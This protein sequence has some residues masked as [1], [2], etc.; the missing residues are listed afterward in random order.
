V[1]AE[2]VRSALRAGAPDDVRQH[3]VDVDGVRWPPKQAL[4]LATGIDRREFTSHLAL[5]QLQRLGFPTS[6]WGTSPGPRPRTLQADGRVS[7]VSQAQPK[8]SIA[9]ILLVGCTQSKAPSAR[10]ASELFTG[11]RFLKAR[12]LAVRSGKPWYVLSAKFGLIAPEEVVAPYDVYLADQSSEYRNAWG[13]WVTAQL[14][15]RR[16]LSGAKIEVHA[17]Q[18]YC[19]PL[20]APLAAAGATLCQ[21]LAGL[22]QG[23]QLA[24]Y[25]RVSDRPTTD[26]GAA[27]MTTTA[28]TADVGFLLDEGNA[29]PPETVL[30]A[31]RQACDQPGLYSWWSDAAGSHDL[32]AGLGHR[33]A[34]GLIYAGRAGGLRPTGKLSTNTLW[35]RIAT[36]HLGGNR[37]FS[38]FRLSLAA[39]LTEAGLSIDDET[40]L[41]AWMRQH[42]RV[43]VLPL[44]AEAVF[45]AEQRLL[46][47]ADPPL[48]LRDVE[49]TEL[50]RRLTELR[51]A[52]GARDPRS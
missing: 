35:G 44:P 46:K 18:A 11:A 10:P 5:R 39:V 27:P 51:S 24:W 49:K 28:A 40:A 4:S 45:T 7:G 50:R 32:S 31:G 38:T 42:L 13:R 41:T 6:S 12:D 9:D 23:E 36:M 26:E 3:W 2:A 1:D 30:A 16:D 47:L 19:E 17:G 21:P 48:N 29:V 14:V 22:R 15:A 37:E 43:A 33:V 34:P 8:G 20:R 52:L 25:G